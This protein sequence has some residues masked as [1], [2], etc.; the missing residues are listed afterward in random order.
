MFMDTKLKCNDKTSSAGEKKKKPSALCND[1]PQF[2][3]AQT[4]ISL[5]N[6]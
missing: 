5:Y 2:R 1:N 3:K 6:V 4:H